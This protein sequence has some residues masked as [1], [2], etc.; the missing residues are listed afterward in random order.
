[1]KILVVNKDNNG[2]YDVTLM[3][4]SSL[5]RSGQPFFVPDFAP[6][7]TATPMLAMRIGR[8]GKCIARRFAHRYVD[9]VTAAIVTRGVTSDLQPLDNESMLA[10]MDGA[11]MMGQWT[12]HDGTLEMP[13]LR[14][15]HNGTQHHLEECALNSRPDEVIEHLSRYCTLKMGDIVCLQYNGTVPQP[16]DINDKLEAFVSDKQVL[17]NKVK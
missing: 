17:N 7:F 3:A 12:E 14:W 6:R 13:T 9:A 8:L 15:C 1:M 5:L 2:A 11:A 4:D 16:L 10:F